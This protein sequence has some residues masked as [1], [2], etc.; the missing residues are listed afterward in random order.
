[1]RGRILQDACSGAVS[2][3]VRV[4]YFDPR[5][6]EP[7]DEKPEPLHG[8]QERRSREREGYR[9]SPNNARNSRAVVVDGERYASIADAADAI[10]Y[11]PTY[12]AAELRSGRSDYGGRVVRY[13]DRPMPEPKPALPKEPRRQPPHRMRPVTVDGTRYASVKEAA[14]ALG[15]VPGTIHNALKAGRDLVKGHAVAYA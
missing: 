12:L 10:G 8:D 14:E 6:G 1:M 7:C 9:A 11:N 5:T 3:P 4:S 2:G 13:A 15:C